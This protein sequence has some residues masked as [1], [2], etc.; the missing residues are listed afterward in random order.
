MEENNKTILAVEDGL[1]VKTILSDTDINDLN[2]AIEESVKDDEIVKTVASLPS[3]NGTVERDPE[4][5]IDR[6]EFKKMNVEVDPVTGEHKILY[7]TSIGNTDEETEKLEKS[8]NESFEEMIARVDRGEVSYD[9]SEG[10][11][12]TKEDLESAIN[13]GKSEEESVY[14]EIFGDKDISEG[15]LLKLLDIVNRKKNGEDFNVY[16]ELTESARK[17]IDT[18][19]KSGIAGSYG[20]IKTSQYNQYRNMVAETL[21]SDFMSNIE[22]SRIQKDL[23]KEI[24]SIFN[25]STGE[26]ADSIIGYTTERNAK[27]REYA[28]TMDDEEKKVKVLAILDNIDEAYNLTKLKEFSKKCKIRAI[29]IEPKN[30][31]SNIYILDSFLSKYNNSNYSIYSIYTAEQVLFRILNEKSMH[32]DDVGNITFD[33]DVE[34]SRPIIRA[35]LIA[36]ANQCANYKPTNVEEHAY[37]YYVL[38]NIVLTDLNKGQSKEVSDIFINNIKECIA[39]LKARNSS[40]L[41]KY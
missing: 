26:I 34:Y 6:G 41:S 10:S 29:D 37:M 21:I 7:S 39:N 32:Q 16:K 18:Q 5:I 20:V 3:N 15:D 24:E 9:K 1:P 4:T 25:K 38:Y 17:L 12:F 27:Y 31:N 28:N 13:S 19:V 33:E 35:F 14:K 36:F 11:E 23:H 40:L 8:Y 2:D 22:I 30:I